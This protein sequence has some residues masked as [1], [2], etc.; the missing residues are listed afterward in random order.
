MGVVSRRILLLTIIVA[1][2]GFSI[3]ALTVGSAEVA[4]IWQV[5]THP[6]QPGAGQE[7][8]WGIRFP[9]ILA[10]I[11]VGIA[12]GIAGALAQSATNSPL[13]DPAI[14]GTSAGASVG[15]ALALTLNVAQV[16][17]ATVAI[18]ATIGALLAS[19]ATFSLSRSAMQLIIIG[20]ATSA[21]FSAMAS[22]IIAI[23]NRPDARSI[24]F[25]SLGSFALANTSTLQ[26]LAPVVL[27]VSIIGWYFSQRMD[28]LILGDRGVRHLGI[29]PQRIRLGAFLIISI[30]IG[31]SVSSVG[32][33]AFVALAAPHITRFLI[34]PRNRPLVIGSG[35]I[36]AGL[37]LVAD[38]AARTI[39]APQEL[40][41]G[42]ITS[43]IGAPLLILL[44]HKNRE[45]WR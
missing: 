29:E 8:I 42:L 2:A 34:G 36:G 25:W 9:R 7:I 26:L 44:L 32:S 45:V 3:F 40:P 14:I 19:L 38:T 41:I 11:L 1:I 35:V 18:A 21:L 10:A 39:A 6:T 28:L 20:I 5:I 13:A 17:S 33:I 15:A 37:M 16:G 12:L 24:S 4:S 31:V 22:L 23:G 43:L 30:L 27:I